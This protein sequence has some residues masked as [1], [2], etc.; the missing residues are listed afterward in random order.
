MI[1]LKII[2]YKS[3]SN[4]FSKKWVKHILLCIHDL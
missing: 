4:L 1:I 3:Y 2:L